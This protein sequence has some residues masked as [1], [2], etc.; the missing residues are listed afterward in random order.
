MA[1]KVGKCPLLKTVLA[2]KIYTSTCCFNVLWPKTHFFFYLR[3]RKNKRNIK[4]K[5]K[6]WAFGH[7]AFSGRFWEVKDVRQ[8]GV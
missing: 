1:K 7:E 2:T 5:R 3:E 8:E 4:N 6:K